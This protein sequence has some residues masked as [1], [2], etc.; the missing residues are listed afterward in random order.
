VEENAQVAIMFGQGKEAYHDN[1]WPCKSSNSPNLED[2]LYPSQK[3]E[4]LKN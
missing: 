4:K 1:P 3:G 2:W